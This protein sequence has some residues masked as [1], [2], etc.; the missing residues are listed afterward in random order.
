ML[1]L[2]DGG[3]TKCDWVLLNTSGE[4]LFHTQSKGLYP[5]VFKKEVLQ[6][7]L[8]ENTELFR[9]KDIVDTIAFFGAGCGTP[10]P[11][12]VLHEVFEQVFPNAA[13]T[14]HEDMMAAV[15]AVT[16]EP[17]IVCILGTGSNSCYFDGK[18]SHQKVVSLGYTL[19]DE[20]SGNYFGKRLLQ[21]YFYKKMPND[22]AIAFNEKY[23][24]DPDTIK[25]NLYHSEQPNAYLASFGAFLF[26][27][28]PD[29]RYIRQLIIEGVEDF[30]DKRVLCY[31]R[32]EEVPVHFVGSIAYYAKEIIAQVSRRYELQVGNF[33]KRPIDGLIHYFQKNRENS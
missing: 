14:I 31:E 27:W 17:G 18:K 1:L 8:V 4:V 6:E 28:N 11:V 12:E 15:Y 20:A 10:R 16:T 2:A 22:I 9:V 30:L 33:V 13:F 23:N 32:H 3:S 5:T 21:D 7:R 19:M 26:D 25:Y 29:N 24:L